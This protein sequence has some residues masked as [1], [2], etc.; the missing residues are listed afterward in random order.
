VRRGLAADALKL[1]A[2]GTAGM[3][4]EDAILLGNAAGRSAEQFVLETFALPRSPLAAA[5]AEGRRIDVAGLITRTRARAERVDVLVLE[6]VG[7]LLVPLTGEATVADVFRSLDAHMI[8]VARAGLG[9]INH[10][11]LTVEAC[12]DRGLRCAGVLLSNSEN[13]DPAFAEENAAQI[14]AQS[15]VPVLGVLPWSTAPNDV[16][17][18][19]RMLA[20][21]V[22]LDD[23]C[24]LGRSGIELRARAVSAD[25]R[26]VWHPFTQ[27]TEWSDEEPLVIRAG[28]GS[29]LIDEDGRRYLD[30]VASLW[31]NVHGHAHPALDH[32]LREQA[33]RVAHTT[34]LGLTHAP[35]AL[36]AE[37]L[38]QVAPAGLD[39]VFYSESGAAAVEVALRIA[40][41][42]QQR[43]GHPE[44]TRFLSL[45]EAYHGDTAGAV[46]VGRSEPFHRG[47][48][49]L[50][51]DVVRVPSPH[52]AGEE[53][54]LECL[55]AA[56]AS[57]AD[58][59]A[60]FVVEPRMQGAAGMLP[61]SDGWLRAAIGR[62]R[63]AGLLIVCDEV[64]TGFGR[65]GD[66]FASAGARVQ[67]DILVLGKGLSGGYLPLS[68]TMVGEELYALFTGPY[69]EH[70]TLYYGHTY[71]ANPLACAVAR[72]SLELFRTEDTVDRARGLAATLSRELRAIAAIESVAEIRQR[73]VMIGLELRNPDGSAFDPA[74]RIGRRVTLAARRRGVI[75]R[76][77]GDVIVINPPLVMSTG[78]ASLLV[79]ALGDALA[80]VGARQLSR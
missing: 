44:R 35:G 29:W 14:A 20:D 73:G 65:T 22:D 4:G 56:L 23:L 51:F 12:H 36:L 19:A 54:A 37:E 40:L 72:V 16:D 62:A 9:T 18:V 10:S 3:P 15:G 71:T 48:D 2:T 74:L 43:H 38:A 66:L 49:P 24:V 26:H 21:C 70:R 75:V 8:I 27:T 50:L 25:R 45:D 28:E 13:V 32:A 6:G 17:T 46:S 69:S 77:L 63:A 60:A 41:L 39:R 5:T 76:P 61:H 53:A 42:A 68:A 30:G 1:L 34:F 33:G 31:A 59:I 64:A 55:D 58:T 11:V 80:E 67:P 52:V 47:L 7:G 57:H 78:E 79:S